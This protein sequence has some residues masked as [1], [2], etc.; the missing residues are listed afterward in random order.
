MQYYLLPFALA[1]IISFSQSAFSQI[2]Q[3]SDLGK[4]ATFLAQADQSTLVIFDIDEVL[5]QGKDQIFHPK[6]KKTQLSAKLDEY[7][8]KYGTNF[9]NQMVSI[10]LN[11]RKAV[12]VDKKIL[13]LLNYLNQK[14]I[15][16]I[17]LTH[18]STGSMGVIEK[19]EDWRINEL[20]GVGIVFSTFTNDLIFHKL[21]GKNERSPLLKGGILFTNFVDKSL[22]LHQFLESTGFKPKKIIF[23][24]DDRNNLE[25]TEKLCVAMG[26]DFI[27]IEYLAATNK[28][29][30]AFNKER[31]NFQFTILEKQKKWLSDAEADQLLQTSSRAAPPLC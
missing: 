26:I 9:M 11:T 27:G 28:P 13:E 8:H 20:K 16:T 10:I 23:I 22:V 1:F 17:A 21:H 6:Y 7:A 12:L 18:C 15:P 5:I 29:C 31:M 3:T 24:D 25:L 19:V 2:F 4:I 14:K 30:L